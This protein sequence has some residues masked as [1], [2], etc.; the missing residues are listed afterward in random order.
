VLD[1]DPPVTGTNIRWDQSMPGVVQTNTVQLNRDKLLRWDTWSSS[2]KT[3]L[4]SQPESFDFAP[5]VER[6][7]NAA[8]VFAAWF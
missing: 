2:A 5:I 4:Q 7:V 3:F 8:N 6:Y 1:E